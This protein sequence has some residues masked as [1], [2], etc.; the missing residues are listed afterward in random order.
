MKIAEKLKV[1]LKKMLSLELGRVSTD[2]GELVYDGELAVGVEVFI[3]DENGELQPAPD[4]E[5]IAE[6][7][8]IIVKDGKVAEIKEN[9][10]DDKPAEEAAE[11][12]A[13]ENQDED[14]NDNE[15]VEAEQIDEPAAESAEAPAQEEAEQENLEDK[16]ARLEGLVNGFV[17]GLDKI[18]NAIA[19]LEDRVAELENKV[20]DL[21]NEPAAEPAEQPAAEEE[22]ANSRLAYLRKNK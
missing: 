13:E 7:S 14:Q 5:Y 16:V 3:E 12:P 11:E 1:A 9:E 15:N 8:T 2:K 10:P 18:V 21:D 4:G 20:K 22:V 17:E 6:N 19:A